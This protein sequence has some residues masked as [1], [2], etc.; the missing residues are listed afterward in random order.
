[1]PLRRPSRCEPST[2]PDGP[3][4][5]TPTPTDETTVPELQARRHDGHRRDGRDSI[6]MTFCTRLY[7]IIFIYEG[8]GNV[9]TRHVPTSDE[10]VRYR[11]RTTMGPLPPDR[12]GREPSAPVERVRDAPVRAA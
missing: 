1:M 8:L 10:G 12:D 5:D 9:P 3:G 11:C 6:K 7:K 4:D 2:S